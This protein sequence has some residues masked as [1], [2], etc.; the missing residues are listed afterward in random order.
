MERMRSPETRADTKQK[1]REKQQCN[2][3]T[4]SIDVL[5]SVSLVTRTADLVI[6]VRKYF[7]KTTWKVFIYLK[8]NP[9][10][11]KGFFFKLA[12]SALMIY[13]VKINVTM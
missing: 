8:E 6:R 7:D 1:V 4:A 3:M 10:Q 2:E 12:K 13:D 5:A 11:I 9:I